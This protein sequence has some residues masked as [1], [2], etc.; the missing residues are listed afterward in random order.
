MH[1]AMQ[2]Q[3]VK[4]TV[5]GVVEEILSALRV[6]STYPLDF[7]ESYANKELSRFQD[8]LLFDSISRV[9]RHPLRK[10]RPA[11]HGR[12]IGALELCLISGVF[13]KHLLNG[14]A[15]ALHY[16]HSADDDSESIKLI[17]YYGISA[18]LWHFLAIPQNSLSSK[19]VSRAYETFNARNFQ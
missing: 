16:D 11:P 8:T 4:D 1:E 6:S 13:P 10:L 3:V 15:A 12:L 7:L 14:I 18:F 9:A 2:V 5:V 17:K 19:L